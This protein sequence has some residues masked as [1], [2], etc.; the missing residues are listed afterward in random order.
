VGDERQSSGAEHGSFGDERQ[1]S[2]DEHGSSGAEQQNSGVEHRSSGAEQQSSGA[3][4]Q[5]SGAE[6]QSSG[7]E[8]QRILTH[9]LR[10]RGFTPLS[11][12]SPKTSRSM[13]MNS[14]HWRFNKSDV[15]IENASI[16]ILYKL[17]QEFIMKKKSFGFKRTVLSALLAVLTFASCPVSDDSNGETLEDDNTAI[18]EQIDGYIKVLGE[19]LGD[20]SS[21]SYDLTLPVT[22]FYSIKITWVSDKPTIV[23]PD[24]VVNRPTFEEGDAVVKLTATFSKSELSRIQEYIV[25]VKAYPEGYDPTK[26]LKVHYTFAA[27]TG[28][29]VPDIEGTSD[30]TLKNGATLSSQAGIGI[31]DLGSANGYLDIG[32]GLGPVLSDTNA[33]TVST[34]L[35]V[36]SSA[37]LAGDGW[38]PWALATFDPVQD[39][40]PVIWFQVR[41]TTMEVDVGRYGWSE[42]VWVYTGDKGMPRE[43]W[44]HF[45]YTQ[46]G[47]TGRLYYNGIQVAMR[48]DCKPLNELSATTSGPFA[49]NYLGKSPFTGDSYM[50]DSKYADFRLYS[51]ALTDFSDMNIDTT[52]A[53]LNGPAL[54]EGQINSYI[55]QVTELLG[56]LSGVK[57][58]IGLPGGANGI[59]LTW[60]SSNPAVVGIDGA[61]TRPG[62]GSGSV[63]VTLTGT[64]SKGGV[65]LSHA[66][67]VTV[68]AG[69]DD[70]ASVA[71]DKAELKID[72]FINYFYHII[73]LP[74]VGAEGSD[75]TWSSNNISYPV[76]NGKVRIRDTVEGS[77]SLTLTA[78]IKKSE[79]SDTKTF[80]V[81]A[82]EK[83]FTNGAYLLVY[84]VGAGGTTIDERMRFALSDNGKDFVALNN[85]EPVIESTVVAEKGGIRDPFIS[86]GKDGNFLLV[87]TDMREGD[88][89][90]SNRGIV[91]MKSPDLLNWTYS[92]VNIAT[93]FPAKFGDIVAAWAPEFIYDREQDKYLVFFS[94]RKSGGIDTIYYSYANAGFTDLVDEPQQFF[95]HPDNK[96]AIDGDIVYLNGKYNLFFKRHSEDGATGLAQSSTLVPFNNLNAA[97][98]R[99]LK[100]WNCFNDPSTE[101]TAV[102]RQTFGADTDTWILLYDKQPNFLFW[103]STDFGTFTQS[104][105][106]LKT[107]AGVDISPRH[108]SVVQIT[109]SEKAAL[110]GRSVWPLVPSLGN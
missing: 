105:G 18:Y 55:A 13:E 1:G 102:Y 11:S 21:V 73:D 57:T 23:S 48:E 98:V 110:N 63:A 6:Q 12:R 71:S 52:L 85:N 103:T 25:T 24:G 16:N 31:L 33:I 58:D 104:S 81:T 34:F 78:T 90:D 22:G 70:A 41:D 20:L 27:S 8:Q 76:S 45:I 54:Y 94:L 26:I 14:N 53:S 17:V 65:T 7:A 107:G 68:I 30:G 87:A 37:T 99:V 96:S 60:T 108:G 51:E 40:H 44:V 80:A 69:F 77:F 61:V 66:Y 3:K 86:R 15:Q 59:T 5:S 67:Q 39:Q 42:R 106:S 36:A 97:G 88:G 91:M 92:R 79:V 64:F 10:G 75:I 72:R 83:D 89:W 101:G 32:A 2:G 38:F 100:N 109:A 74:D 47:A 43:E 82:Q 49:Y 29:T 95:Y 46:T 28:D 50:K 35:Y 19:Q 56:D 84:F 9:A 62:I 4:Q 93:K